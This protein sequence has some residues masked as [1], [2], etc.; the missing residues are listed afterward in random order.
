M[1]LSFWYRHAT[2]L[3]PTDACGL[4]VFHFGDFGEQEGAQTFIWTL[5]L[6]NSAAW[7]DSPG[8]GYV[9]FNDVGIE[10]KYWLNGEG[11]W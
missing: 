2:C 10:S 8:T 6:E 5:W 11:T 4:Y 3:Q 7:L 1:T 9:K